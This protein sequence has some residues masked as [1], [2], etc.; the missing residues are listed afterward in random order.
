MYMHIPFFLDSMVNHLIFYDC[1][2]CFIQNF[3]TLHCE[4]LKMKQFDAY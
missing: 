1:N 3:K 2:M 4:H